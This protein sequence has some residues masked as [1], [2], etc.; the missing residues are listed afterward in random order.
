MVFTLVCGVLFSIS[1]IFLP[2]FSSVDGKKAEA[3]IVLMG[4]I[5][6]IEAFGFGLLAILGNML[7][8][9]AALMHFLGA[10]KGAIFVSITAFVFASSIFFMGEVNYLIFGGPFQRSNL[11]VGF[12]IWYSLFIALIVFCVTS[13]KIASNQNPW[14]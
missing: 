14:K 8:V 7:W 4:L 12:V 3:M 2:M 11:S 6:N 10:Y 5:P 1:F 9:V 13:L